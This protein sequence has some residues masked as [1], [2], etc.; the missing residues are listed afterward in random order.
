MFN[1]LILGQQ[2]IVAPNSGPIYIVPP[3]SQTVQTQPNQTIE[4]ISVQSHHHI[5]P[6][7]IHNQHDPQS[8]INQTVTIDNSANMNQLQNIQTEPIENRDK[9]TEEVKN[10]LTENTASRNEND[11]KED[12]SN[13]SSNPQVIFIFN[14]NKY[15][16]IIY[17]LLLILLQLLL[18]QY[19]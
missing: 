12:S 18:S 1:H 17:S 10:P 11:A 7:S 6:N 5:I 15:N 4:T 19:I 9:D 16:T 3:P 14:T 2:Y 13:D 8:I